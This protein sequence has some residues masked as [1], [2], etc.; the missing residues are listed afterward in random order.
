MGRKKAPIEGMV[1]DLTGNENDEAFDIDAL[2]VAVEAK[3]EKPVKPAVPAVTKTDE[4]LLDEIPDGMHCS[5]CHR[6]IFTSVKEWKGQ[7]VCANCHKACRRSGYSKELSE[8]VR[9]VYLRGCTFCD[10]RIGRFHLD[11]INMFTKVSSVG[12]MM[13]AGAPAVDIIAE[14]DKCQLLC[15]NCHG[16]VTKFEH[17]R[18]FIA[19]KKALNR[20]IAK[21]ED[22]VELRQRLHDVYDGVMTK[23]Y[24]LIRAKA[25]RV[26]GICEGNMGGLEASGDSNDENGELYHESDED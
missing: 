10:I 24:P 18:G 21:G 7:R 15:V 26:W 11:H 19:D 23:M 16:L 25:V 14:I 20:R 1:L 6:S 3:A 9:S 13:E 8:Y 12:E 4:E 22:V 2:I 5:V 17:K